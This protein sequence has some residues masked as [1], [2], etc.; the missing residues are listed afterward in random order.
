MAR[1]AVI[2]A[3]SAQDVMA[4]FGVGRTV[5]YRRLRALVDQHTRGRTPGSWVPRCRR[6]LVGFRKYARAVSRAASLWTAPALPSRWHLR[7]C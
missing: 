5:G 3:V 2:G 1:I 7:P 4:R 6:F